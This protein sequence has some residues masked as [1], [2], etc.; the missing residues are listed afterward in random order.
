MVLLDGAL[1]G[2]ATGGAI[3]HPSGDGMRCIE[4][5]NSE[6]AEDRRNRP[7]SIVTCSS[8]RFP[9]R[10]F[11]KLRVAQTKERLWALYRDAP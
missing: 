10:A 3:R 4:K 9:N 5:C 11:P 2:S 6:Q 8:H 7:P 1:A